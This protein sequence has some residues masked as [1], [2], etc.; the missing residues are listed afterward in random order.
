MGAGSDDRDQIQGQGNRSEA[1]LMF[2]IR[3][4]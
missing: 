1:N 4:N 3:M 2:G